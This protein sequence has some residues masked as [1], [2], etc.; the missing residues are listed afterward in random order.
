MGGILK[1]WISNGGSG[2]G[3]LPKIGDPAQLFR[4]YRKPLVAQ[5]VTEGQGRTPAILIVDIEREQVLTIGSLGIGIRLSTDKT[6]RIVDE[7]LFQALIDEQ[8]I[9]EKLIGVITAMMPPVKPP[10]KIVIS[11]REL[12]GTAGLKLAK[13][14]IH[15]GRVGAEGNSTYVASGSRPSA[16]RAAIRSCG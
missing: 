10:A 5:T 7:E 9:K 8:A 6:R 12:K 14:K 4:G 2:I 3:K 11:G 15:V 13:G 1:E 16:C